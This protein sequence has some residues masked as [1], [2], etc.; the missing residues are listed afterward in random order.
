MSLH[1]LVAMA[2]QVS[3]RSLLVQ[4]KCSGNILKIILACIRSQWG[5]EYFVEGILSILQLLETISF[6]PLHLLLCL[7]SQVTGLLLLLQT[8]GG[9][10]LRQCQE[11]TTSAMDV[12]AFGM[13][14]LL[15]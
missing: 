1:M 15:I 12:L 2:N 14:F 7:C 9:L 10:S 13:V 11:L 4:A 6:F 8:E 3:N 5:S